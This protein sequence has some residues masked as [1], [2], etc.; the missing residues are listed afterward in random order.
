MSKVFLFLMFCFLFPGGN[1]FSQ[2]KEITGIVYDQTGIPLPGT[3]VSIKDSSIKVTTDFNGNFKIIIPDSTTT[4]IFSYV[5]YSSLEYK[6]RTNETHVEV[7]LGVSYYDNKWFTIGLNSDISNSLFGIKLSNGFEEL[8]LIHFEDI[9]STLLYL[10]SF[11]TDFKNDYGIDLKLKLNRTRLFYKTSLQF[12][13]KELKSNDLF[14]RKIDL[15]KE[16]Y[17][18]S[19]HFFLIPSIGFQELN[20]FQNMGFRLGIQNEFDSFYFGASTGY[21]FDYFTYSI[22][23]QSFIFNSNW[24]C[25]F[26]Y[27]RI[28]NSDFLTFALQFSFIKENLKKEYK[29]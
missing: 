5:G 14:I 27:D 10:A 13:Q 25:R 29:N 28:N 21:Y 23:I 3:F 2:K 12:Q 22:Y 1:C 24:G 26:E 19:L 18:R 17:V 6:L 16:F 7:R 20:D 9:N 8:P 11:Q 15:S 4:L